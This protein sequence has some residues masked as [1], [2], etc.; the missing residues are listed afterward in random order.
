MQRAR[1]QKRYV[2]GHRP[3]ECSVPKTQKNEGLTCEKRHGIVGTPSAVELFPSDADRSTFPAYVRD[4]KFV[5]AFL[6]NRLPQENSLGF[7]QLG[8]AARVFLELLTIPEA[9]T[10][11]DEL[12]FLEPAMKMVAV[13]P[14]GVLFRVGVEQ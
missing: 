2:K 11:L 7:P 3:K 6:H 4:A 10:E 8:I 14:I 9:G 1:C 12:C 13:E 5:F